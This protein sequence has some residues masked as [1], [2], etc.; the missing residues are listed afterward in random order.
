MWRILFLLIIIS[1]CKSDKE[2][3]TKAE[4]IVFLLKKQFALYQSFDSI[5]T[6]NVALR[7]RLEVA[8]QNTKSVIEFTLGYKE[9]I[10]EAKYL[11]SKMEDILKEKDEIIKEEKKLQEKNDFLIMENETYKNKLAVE[12]EHHNV[13][14]KEKSKAQANVDSLSKLT[15]NSFN[16]TGLGT[17]FNLYFKSIYYETKKENK[18]KIAKVS[19]TFP[20]NSFAKKEKKEILVTMYSTDKKDI[21]ERDTTVNYVGEEMSIT[22]LLKD[23]VFKVGEHLVSIRINGRFEAQKIFIVNH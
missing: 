13:T 20:R 2:E 18:I 3:Q 10:A 5:K 8:K 16:I 1:S 23:K 7:N 19:F 9:A 6:D 14:K 21:I 17:M 22:M 15:I 11:N 12:I 4:T